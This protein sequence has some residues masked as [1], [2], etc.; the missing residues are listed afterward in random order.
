[1]S[2]H[3]PLGTLWKEVYF[4]SIK[5]A[6]ALH[7]GNALEVLDELHLA[8]SYDRVY[9]YVPYLRGLAQLKQRD[10][11]AAAAEFRKIVD[12]AGSSWN[13]SCPQFH[14][15]S[16]LGLARAQ[17]MTGELDNARATYKDLL[18]YWKDADSDYKPA[19]EAR[20]EYQTLIK[21]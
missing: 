9:P 16:R 14:S 11:H 3:M 4:P 6:G 5:A 13:I 19:L 20:R 17:A 8:P 12:H 1:M 18:E 21:Q 7:S 15:L 2:D 10:G